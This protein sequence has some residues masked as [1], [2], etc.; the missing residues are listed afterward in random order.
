MNKLFP[1]TDHLGIDYGTIAA[2]CKHYNVNIS[3]YEA[4]KCRGYSEEDALLG[5]NKEHYNKERKKKQSC[6]C[7]YSVEDCYGNVFNS[8]TE[9]CKHYGVNRGT[10]TSRI[11]RGYTEYEALFG[12]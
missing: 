10:Y 11:D 9:K 4:R 8:V 2:K 1:T 6:R 12:K 3:T 7:N 5:T